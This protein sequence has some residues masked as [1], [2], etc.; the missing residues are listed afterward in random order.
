MAAVDTAS[1]TE[2]SLPTPP[3]AVGSPDGPS[4]SLPSS[5]AMPTEALPVAHASGPRS[6]TTSTILALATGVFLLVVGLQLVGAFGA[7]AGMLL[8]GAV[9]A[10]GPHVPV[11]RML[12]LYRAQ[13]LLPGQVASLHESAA[14]LSG[15]AG[16]ARPPVIAIVPSLASGAFA[17][18]SSEQSAIL[19]TEGLLRRHSIPEIAAIFAHE[20]GH[21]RAGDTTT[22]AL[23]DTLT[24]LAQIL[25]YAAVAALLVNGLLWLAAEPMLAWFP[26]AMMFAAPL[27]SSLLQLL[28]PRAHDLAA[29]RLA[30]KLTG[31]R[32][33]IVKL[34]AAEPT[35]CGTFL[36][37]LRLPVPQRRVPLPSPL[38]AHID[39][40]ARAR[41]L[42]A[43]PRAETAPY[44]ALRVSD[45][46][47]VSLAGV[48]PV[49]MR[50][51]DRWPGVWF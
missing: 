41:S 8:A 21:I 42:A 24:R 28:M 32:D 50:P 19:V 37:D 44:P 16:L 17:V 3:A 15:R 18:G 51:R 5:S 12:A 38:R 22:F 1:R 35:R 4:Q 29:D 2:G 36:D 39:G 33:L 11:E 10:F 46:P 7:F 40:P 25:F 31:D 26:I 20:I 30:A 27:L 6:S 43:E 23:A 47:L 13:Q 9:Y 49:E 14:A 34:A 48:G 45:G